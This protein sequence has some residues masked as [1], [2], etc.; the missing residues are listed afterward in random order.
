M[1]FNT[2]KS[3]NIWQRMLLR[4]FSFQIILEKRK[5]RR[6]KKNW[7]KFNPKLN[8]YF[9]FTSFLFYLFHKNINPR[10]RK[11]CI[12]SILFLHNFC[13]LKL[14]NYWNSSEFRSKVI[15]IQ[16]SLIIKPFNLFN[17]FFNEH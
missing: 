16:S 3:A 2:R 4:H 17:C 7:V 5:T 8:C 9:D 12:I 15:Y 11:N 6:T 10:A 1:L 13:T 14:N